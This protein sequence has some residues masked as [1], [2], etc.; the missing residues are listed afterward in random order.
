MLI[1]AGQNRVPL[2]KTQA[3]RTALSDSKM[4]EAA[5]RLICELGV[6]S[7][8]LKAVGENAG[9]S[10][11]LAS[12][13]F[14]NKDGLLTFVVRSIGDLWLETLQSAVSDK[15]GL[16]AIE[17]AT[18][19]H[20]QFLASNDISTRAFYILW[21]ESINSE[22]ELKKLILKIQERRRNDVREWIQR[23]IT[24]GQTDPKV[25][26]SS[27]TEHFCSAIIGIVYEWLVTRGRDEERI[28]YHHEVLK[29]QMTL[30]LTSLN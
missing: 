6:P 11:G 25:C 9:Y 5:V 22:S 29:K 19:A 28:S 8:T 27:A 10:R 15:V 18:D 24:S 1:I 23:G 17:A 4:L 12:Y 16:A 30:T 3:Q 7:T 2:P 20:Q 26:V 13:R 21:F 14:G